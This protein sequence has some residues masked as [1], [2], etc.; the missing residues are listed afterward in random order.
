[1]KQF[2]ESQ[3]ESDDVKEAVSALRKLALE[4]KEKSVEGV[5]AIPDEVR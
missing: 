3:W 2:L 4:D 1:V 5:V